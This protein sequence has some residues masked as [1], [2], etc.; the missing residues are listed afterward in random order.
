MRSYYS[1]CV[2]LTFSLSMGPVSYQGVLREHL[3]LCVSAAVCPL[4]FF[5]AVGVVSKESRQLVLHRNFCC[6]NYNN[7][8]GYDGVFHNL[9]ESLFCSED[10]GSTFLR[11]VGTFPSNYAMT[12]LRTHNNHNYR[13]EK[14]NI[15]ILG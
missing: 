15:K 5:C 10:E 2:S 3:V 14:S 1:L 13:V 6:N 7:K 12:Y 8:F 9:K 11:N 4:I